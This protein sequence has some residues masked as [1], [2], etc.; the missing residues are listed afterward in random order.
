MSNNKCH[1]LKGQHFMIKQSSQYLQLYFQNKYCSKTISLWAI[2]FPERG[3]S[4]YL[5][6]TLIWPMNQFAVKLS[7][8]VFGPVR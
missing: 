6:Y 5:K 1:L 8:F 2:L 4:F 7:V 3:L